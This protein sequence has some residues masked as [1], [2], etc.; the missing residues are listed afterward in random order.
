MSINKYP[1]I[2]LVDYTDLEP[3]LVIFVVVYLRN[4][5]SHNLIVVFHD[6]LLVIFGGR[7]VRRQ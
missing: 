7:E 4:P 3:S 6:I 2:S 1:L 5:I